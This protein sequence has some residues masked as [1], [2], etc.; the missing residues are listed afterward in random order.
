V[1]WSLRRQTDDGRRASTS[2]PA[3][4][5]MPNLHRHAGAPRMMGG[6][7]APSPAIEPAAPLAALRRVADVTKCFRRQTK[8]G[9]DRSWRRITLP[10]AHHALDIPETRC[11][12][13]ITSRGTVAAALDVMA[14][15]MQA[16]DRR[17]A[18]GERSQLPRPSA[19]SQGQANYC[20]LGC[21]RHLHLL[22]DT[23]SAHGGA[24]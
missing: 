18:N 16:A 3:H 24:R 4:V 13:T 12:V 22:A 10:A 7:L 20:Q 8:P 14:S 5:P 1:K 9:S 17:T 2:F 11:L 23:H 15:P 6:G 21:R 19:T